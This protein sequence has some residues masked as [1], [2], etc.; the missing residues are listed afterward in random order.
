MHTRTSK[1]LASITPDMFA[2]IHPELAVKH[3][4]QDGDMMWL[5]SPQG[6]KIKVKARYSKTVTPDR[7]ALPYNFAGVMQGVDMSEN[8]PE[9]TK[10]YAIGESSNTISNYGFD[11]VSQIPETN[12]GLCRIE[13]A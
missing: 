2:N 5:H 4:L 8:Y 7:I 12:A 11:V 9:G 6:T 13:K 3:G 10:P 1:Y